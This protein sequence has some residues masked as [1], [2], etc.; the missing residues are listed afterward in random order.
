MTRPRAIATN[1]LLI[2][3]DL[4]RSLD[5]YTQKLGFVEPAVWGDPPCFAMMN[6]DGFDL[7]LSSEHA[8]HVHPNGPLEIWD[9][10]LRVADLAGEIE[11]LKAAGVAIVRGPEDKFYDIREIEILDPDGYRWCIGQDITP[12]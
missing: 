3:S 6:R 8:E 2:V 9:V 10:C 4:Q 12:P 11:A 1:P 5:F 7:M